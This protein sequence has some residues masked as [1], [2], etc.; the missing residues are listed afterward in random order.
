MV[1]SIT[2]HNRSIK[3]T[4]SDDRNLAS[5]Q[6][7]HKALYANVNARKATPSKFHVGDKV[8]ITRKKGTFEKGYTPNWKEEVFTISSVKATKRILSR[9][10]LENQFKEP[11]TS[12][13]YS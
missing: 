6:H 9:I 1:E 10:H 5:Y 13:S 12:K 4:P 2:I 3:L 7:V 11:F 8:R